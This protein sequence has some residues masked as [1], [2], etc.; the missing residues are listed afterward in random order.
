MKSFSAIGIDALKKIFNE[1]KFTASVLQKGEIRQKEVEARHEIVVM[2]D[3]ELNL[4]TKDFATMSEFQKVTCYQWS[5]RH[6]LKDLGVGSKTI[7]AHNRA[8]SEGWRQSGYAGKKYI[9]MTIGNA[10]FEQN[11]YSRG[12]QILE[13]ISH[14]VLEYQMSPEDFRIF[15]YPLTEKVAHALTNG[16]IK[17]E[18][19]FKD[20]IP[21]K[22]KTK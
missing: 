10:I 7:I 18:I 8:D 4:T 13:H 21:K 16:S 14:I 15:I 6:G 19:Y 5:I 2:S 1:K 9:Y 20:G 22:I 3:S 17:Q 11:F 12:E